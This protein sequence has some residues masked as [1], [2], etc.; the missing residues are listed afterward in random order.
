MNSEVLTPLLNWLDLAGVAIFALTGA[1]V[2]AKERQTFVTLGFF[3]LVTG[4]GGGTVRD[5]L[6]GAPVFWIQD[7]RVPVVCLAVALFA[8]FTPTRWWEGRFLS[9]ADGLGLAA[10]AV[11]G[12]A[13][14]IEYGLP[15]VSA[16]FMGIITGCVG[17][18][19]RDVLAGR[20]SILMRPELYVTAAALSASVT[21]LGDLAGIRREWVWIAAT[22]AGYGLRLAAI[23]WNLALPAYGRD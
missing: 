16:A 13:K 4:V 20:P 17:G 14:A 12:A 18:I 11:L 19:I 10:Y 23:R 2:A 6:I 8:W 7:A 9:I 1:L 3:S 15:P 22:T 5:L 21:V